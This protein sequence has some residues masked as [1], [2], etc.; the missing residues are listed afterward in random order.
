MLNATLTVFLNVSISYL[1]LE[2]TFQHKTH[3]KVIQKVASFAKNVSF[4]LSTFHVNLL[5]S[6]N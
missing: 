3:I 4:K 2:T 1:P 6:N 5:S